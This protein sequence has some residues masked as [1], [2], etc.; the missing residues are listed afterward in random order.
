MSRTAFGA[1]S[2]APTFTSD[3]VITHRPVNPIRKA[4]IHY[5][6]FREWYAFYRA[7]RN[8]PPLTAYISACKCR[9]RIFDDF[10]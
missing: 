1:F 2:T 3:V 6:A 5:R 8:L 10:M 7:F 4:K 9:E